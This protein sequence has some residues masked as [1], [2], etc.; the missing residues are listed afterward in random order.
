MAE[1][2]KNSVVSSNEVALCYLQSAITVHAMSL[3]TV[4]Q[5]GQPGTNHNMTGIKM[6]KVPGGLDVV[7]GSARAFIPDGNLKV[8]VYGETRN[9]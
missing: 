6:F 5:I 8:V 7:K 4:T 9:A 3:V 2:Q 1:V